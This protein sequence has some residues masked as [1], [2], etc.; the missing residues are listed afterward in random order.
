M[1]ASKPLLFDFK[2]LPLWNA[3]NVDEPSHDLPMMDVDLSDAEPEAFP[4]TRAEDPFGLDLRGAL[5][6]LQQAS[7]AASGSPLL[8]HNHHQ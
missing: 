2:E 6:Q 1:G 3:A 5:E 8:G 7:P 4:S